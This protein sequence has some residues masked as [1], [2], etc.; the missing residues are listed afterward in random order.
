[1]PHSFPSQG[2][3]SGWFDCCEPQEQ[4]CTT[5]LVAENQFNDDGCIPE[6][7]PCQELNEGFGFSNFG[8]QGG[9]GGGAYTECGWAATKSWTWWNPNENYCCVEP[10]REICDDDP[11]PESGFVSDGFT[12]PGS[13]F[14]PCDGGFQNDNV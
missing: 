11:Y 14:D 7:P 9:F 3:G 1:M 12:Y 4:I 13:C 6:P 5:N 8:H 2:F 10:K